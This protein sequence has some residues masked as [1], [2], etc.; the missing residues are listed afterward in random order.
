MFIAPRDDFSGQYGTDA[1][2][3][4]QQINLCIGIETHG[5]DMIELRASKRSRF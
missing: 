4:R 3:M 2:D 1:G 5:Q